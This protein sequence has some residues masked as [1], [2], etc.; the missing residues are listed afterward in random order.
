MIKVLL[1]LAAVFYGWHVLYILWWMVQWWP[2]SY[3]WY[4]LSKFYGMEE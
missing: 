2:F 4:K 3:A 1:T